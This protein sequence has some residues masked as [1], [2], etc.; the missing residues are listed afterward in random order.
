MRKTSMIS[1]ARMP[2]LVSLDRA[3]TEACGVGR[4]EGGGNEALFPEQLQYVAVRQ[5]KHFFTVAVCF[6]DFCTFA[7]GQVGG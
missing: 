4:P 3:A 1:G 5:A 2:R 6:Q 7:H